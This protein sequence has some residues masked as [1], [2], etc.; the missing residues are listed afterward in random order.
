MTSSNRNP[1]VGNYLANSA[2]FAKPIMTHL[3]DLIHRRCPA[4]VKEIKWAFPIP[5]R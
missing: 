1:K 5:I 2:P 4:V 3:R